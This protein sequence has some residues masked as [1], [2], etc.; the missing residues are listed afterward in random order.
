M[1]GLFPQL[2]AIQFPTIH[3]LNPTIHRLTFAS[4]NRIFADV[5]G[6][7]QVANLSLLHACRFPAFA[8]ISM[9]VDIGTAIAITSTDGH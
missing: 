7:L 4:C 1:A 8:S 2:P 9:M 6:C 3:P 5:C